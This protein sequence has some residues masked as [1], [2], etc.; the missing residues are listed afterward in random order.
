M[1]TLTS[2]DGHK[3]EVSE[4]AMQ[5][6]LEGSGRKIPPPDPV[7]TALTPLTEAEYI[8]IKGAPS[9]YMALA[10]PEINAVLTARLNAY[11]AAKK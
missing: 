11:N 7:H 3:Y 8:R 2:P 1:I 6:F 5:T 10:V 9:P 4:E